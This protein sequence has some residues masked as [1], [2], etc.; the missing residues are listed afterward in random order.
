MGFPFGT[1]RTTW[2]QKLSSTTCPRYSNSSRFTPSESYRVKS[3][4]TAR[5]EAR[6]PPTTEVISNPARNV[7]RIV[8]SD[9]LRRADKRSNL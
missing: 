1:V 9:L 3:G 6:S 2:P 8:G 7:A 4:A 5:S